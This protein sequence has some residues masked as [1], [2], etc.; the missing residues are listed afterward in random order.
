M[1][2]WQRFSLLLANAS[3]S[4]VIHWTPKLQKPRIRCE[5]FYFIFFNQITLVVDWKRSADDSFIYQW[6]SASSL[7]CV[8]V[9]KKGPKLFT[10]NNSILMAF[11]KTF[12]Q[13]G[14][15]EKREVRHFQFTAWPDHGVP[16]HPTPFL[17]FLRRVKA[18]NPPDAGPMVVHCRWVHVLSLHHFL[19]IWETEQDTKKPMRMYQ[20]AVSVLN[21][22]GSTT[23]IRKY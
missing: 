6:L 11:M 1:S 18:C 15:N 8:V 22:G 5:Y 23:Y 19:K 2:Y 21:T 4:S 10:A 9:P 3:Y 13:S 20:Y 12:L 7:S 16:E 17:A 14:S